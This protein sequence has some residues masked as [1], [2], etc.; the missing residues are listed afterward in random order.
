MKLPLQRPAGRTEKQPP[1]EGPINTRFDGDEN[2][3]EKGTGRHSWSP[4]ADV[5]EVDG[6]YVIE[7]EL[8]GVRREDVDVD[9]DGN[10]FVVTGEI[11]ER[12]REGLFRHRT[13]SVGHFEFRVTLPGELRREDVEVSLA[14][15][16]LKAYV[17]KVKHGGGQSEKS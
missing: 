16:V 9:L 5:I 1:A 14:Y 7:V 3:S 15:G 4:S 11:K 6:G 12:E 17:P 10:E 13:R 8:P 2:A